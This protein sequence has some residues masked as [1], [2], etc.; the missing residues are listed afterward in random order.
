MAHTMNRRE[1]VAYGMIVAS[2]A[3]IGKSLAADAGH[4]EGKRI[5]TVIDDV[6][7][8]C[9]TN[10]V[11]M[12]G[13]LKAER[14]AELVRQTKP[15]LVVE[16]GTALGY[17]G[18]WI[19][20]ELQAAGSGR[21][22]TLEIDSQVARRAEANFHKAGLQRWITIQVGDARQLVKEIAGP[23][24]FVFIDCNAPNY[25]PCFTGLEKNLSRQAVVVADNAD[26]SA[27]GMRDYL[28]LVRSKYRSRTEWFNVDLPWCRRDAMEI[29]W[30]SAAERPFLDVAEDKEEKI[31]PE[32]DYRLRGVPKVTR[33][34][35]VDYPRYLAEK[36]AEKI[37]VEEHR[38]GYIYFAVQDVLHVPFA[39]VPAGAASGA[40]VNVTHRYKAKVP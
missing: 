13:R 21:L 17:S 34:E 32:T 15:R 22:I 10:Q 11:P 1:W 25:Y 40:Y 38:G 24:D 36:N 2:A 3:L 23:I 6:E 14:L 12:I 20:R 26:L 18:L 4:S 30:L 27:G 33:V 16:C 29:T 35:L 19:G 28:T 5:Q 8:A 31:G 7:K 37:L 39:E 9:L